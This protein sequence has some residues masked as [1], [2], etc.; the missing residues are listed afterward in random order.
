MSTTPQRSRLLRLAL[1]AFA[2]LAAAG[3]ADSFRT[4]PNVA[5]QLMGI[6][7]ASAPVAPSRLVLATAPDL[8][9]GTAKRYLALARH[10]SHVTGKEIVYQ[11][12]HD[13]LSYQRHLRTGGYDLVLASAPVASW[14][15]ASHAHEPLV[16]ASADDRFVLITDG[17][18][19][20]TEVSDLA[21]RRI[22]AP[23][24]PDVGTLSVYVHFDN[25]ARRPILVAD[26]DPGRIYDTLRAGGCEAAVL[27]RDAYDV[28]QGKRHQARELLSTTAM[29]GMTLT[30]G[31]RLTAEQKLAIRR[32]LL[33]AQET[34]PIDNPPG[35]TAAKVR[36]YDG[37]SEL[38]NPLWGFNS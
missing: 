16:R 5:V 3:T 1:C 8:P 38:L 23:A 22:C 33:D 34:R 11:P 7:W 17:A 18:Q 21:G 36:D 14:L 9:A 30:A 25:P 35:F 31:P 20:I 28:L 15:I 29:P 27:P 24:L 37:L 12:S 4:E 10:L 32:A 2:T 19:T 13:W 6:G 26:N